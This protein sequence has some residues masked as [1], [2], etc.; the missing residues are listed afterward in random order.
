LICFVANSTT[1][2][3][4]FASTHT[5]QFPA[6]AKSREGG[7]GFGEDRADSINTDAVSASTWAPVKFDMNTPEFSQVRDPA[8]SEIPSTNKDDTEEDEGNNESMS[9]NKEDEA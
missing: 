2:K 3:A 5:P 4:L 1:A 8:P 7:E 6:E 9:T